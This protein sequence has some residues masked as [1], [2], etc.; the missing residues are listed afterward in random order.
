M[1]DLP[2][3]G[4][5]VFF[6]VISILAALVIIRLPV[7]FQVWSLIGQQLVM[8]IGLAEAWLR[9]DV[10]ML[11]Q[12]VVIDIGVICL[13]AFPGLVLLDYL[14]RKERISYWEKG[15][16]PDELADKNLHLNIWII[17]IAALYYAAD[18]SY[19]VYTF[20]ASISRYFGN[21]VNRICDFGRPPG[22]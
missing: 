21:I 5:A 1:I 20:R 18:A 3:L 11:A 22:S 7:Y 16:Y 19:R 14:Q 8:W 10:L 17:L 12:H 4:V 9:W 15:N 6:G 2:L 13:F